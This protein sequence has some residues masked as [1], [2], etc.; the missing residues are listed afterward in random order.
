MDHHDEETLIAVADDCPVQ[1]SVVPDARGEKRTIA[2]LDYEMLADAPHQ[3]AQEDVLFATWLRR[4]DLAEQ[5]QADVDSL[6][7]AFFSKPRA[8]LRTPPLPKRHG[9]GLHCDANGRVA[10]VPMESPHYRSLLES[11]SVKVLE[12]MHYEVASWLA[13]GPRRT[14]DEAVSRKD[15]SGRRVSRHDPG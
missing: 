3:G 1:E 6:R 15:R 7:E 9:W 2:Q 10:L 14:L 8:C 5:A 11:G 13:G 12:A 4:Q